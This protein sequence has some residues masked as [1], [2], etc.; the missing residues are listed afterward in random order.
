V[1]F[2]LQD[3]QPGEVSAPVQ[4]VDEDN[5]AYWAMIRLE[6][7]FPAHRA[8]PTDDY[9][10]FQ[11]QVE[12]EMREEALS[13]WIDKRIGE[14]Y[15]RVDGPYRDCAMDMPW[16]TESSTRPEPCVGRR[17]LPPDGWSRPQ[18]HPCDSSDLSASGPTDV[19]IFGQQP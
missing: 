14:T 5:R 6:E 12:A 16:L 4:L 13:K 3:L 7:R 9:A 18:A 11:Q 10:L 15:V 2:L 17:T 8:N 1:F 19:A